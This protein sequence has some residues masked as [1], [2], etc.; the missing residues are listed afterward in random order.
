MP[1][2]DDILPFS[3]Q[4]IDNVLEERGVIVECRGGRRRS[5]VGGGEVADDGREA[6][7]V[8]EGEPVVVEVGWGEA[9]GNDD[10]GW[11]RCHGLR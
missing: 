5:A 7:F 3:A 8:Q 4:P 9:A 1:E 6:R 2:S 10:Y 11:F